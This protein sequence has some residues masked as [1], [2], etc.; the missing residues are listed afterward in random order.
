MSVWIAFLL[1]AFLI[2]AGLA[3]LQIAGK[4]AISVFQFLFQ[5]KRKS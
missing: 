2:C 3:V 5:K 4:A 1:L